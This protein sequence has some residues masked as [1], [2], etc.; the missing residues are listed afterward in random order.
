MASLELEAAGRL[1]VA[2]LVGLAV[3]VERERSGH[4]TGP[5]ARFAGVRTFFILGLQGGVAGWLLSLGWTA[6]A[7]VLLASGA[8]LALTAYAV[9][10]RAGAGVDGTTEAA[11]LAVLALALA[12]GLG[13]LALAG[14]VA[15]VL[16]F[17]LSEKDLVGRLLQRVDEL[18]LRATFQFAVL[19]LVILPLLPTGPFGPFGTIRPRA[20]WIVVLLFTGINFAGYL[21]RRAMGPRLGYGLTGL[22]GGLISSTAVT[23][24]FSRQSRRE[25]PLAPAL[26]LGVLAACTMLLPRIGLVTLLLNPGLAAAL[27]PFLLPPLLLGMLL[28]ALALQ[29]A[30]PPPQDQPAELSN[31]LQFWFAIR[32]ALAFQLVLIAL[33]W[34]RL[35]FGASGVLTSA[36]LL[37]LTDMDALT[38]SMTRLAAAPDLV[39]LAA[40][41]I[42]IGVLANG[43]LKLTL[44]LAFGVPAFRR[45][46]SA[47]LLA[48]IAASGLGLWWGW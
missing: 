28:L 35:H 41:A 29:R 4:A 37:G 38:L 32:M 30:A 43:V 26:G 21:A 9:A 27:V 25:A 16:V 1:A 33:A 20:L 42:A 24:G 46:A 22:F 44:T 47:G 5:R 14:G 13:H 11:A 36:A 34:V 31:P 2:G 18:E 10:A 7:V 48:L 12:A 8:A 6:A 40:R 3:G 17:A 19:A 15:A 23:F 45:T 39:T